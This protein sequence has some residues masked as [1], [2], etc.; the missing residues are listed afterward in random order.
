[1]SLQNFRARVADYKQ[2]S[3]RYQSIHLE[4]VEPHRIEFVAGQYIMLK[5]PGVVGVRQY[6]IAS[7][8]SMDHG[9]ELLADIVPGGKGSAYLAKL[10]PGDTVEFMAPAG[11]FVIND[12]PQLL[13]V[14]TG[15]GIAPIKSMIT[16]LLV[17][18]KD[19][20][21]MW[22]YWGMRHPEDIFW[23]DNFARLAEEY[24]NLYFDMVLSQPKPGWELC[25]GRVTD[26]LR[27]HE[28][29]WDGAK[30]GAYICGNRKMIEEVQGWLLTQGVDEQRIHHEQFY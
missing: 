30:M 26:C 6:S 23:F 18:K 24:E 14:A 20:R 12:E 15:S 21:Q 2:W 10:K 19:T 9:L 16:D 25:Q 4:L 13:F 1:M 27:T 29:K 7:A 28:H 17:D 11:A 22:L 5:V 3:P 8:P